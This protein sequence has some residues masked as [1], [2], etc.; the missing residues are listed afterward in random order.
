MAAD[1][2]KAKAPGKAN[3]IVSVAALTVLAAVGGG[4]VGKIIMAKAR[5]VAVAAS[6]DVKSASPYAGDI[7]V[8]ELPPIVT[9]LV[10]PPETRVRLQ[11]SILYSKKDIENPTLLVGQIS[12][13]LVAFLKT[14]SLSN[15]Q[16]ASG[17]QALR[18]DLNE[19]ANIRSQGK[20]R[21]L[22]IETLVV[23]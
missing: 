23:Q 19:R 14:L 13:D 8:R 4:L 12:D 17:L 21:E 15:L 10:D 16:G 18:E 1:T 11:V 6:P 22:T 2:I 7:E 3:L 20:V 5:A 9:N